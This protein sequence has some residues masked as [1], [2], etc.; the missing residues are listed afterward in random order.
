MLLLG[1]V[2]KNMYGTPLRVFITISNKII[3]FHYFKTASP[4]TLQNKIKT[5]DQRIS[6]PKNFFHLDKPTNALPP[7]DSIQYNQTYWASYTDIVKTKKLSQ[8]DYISP[9]LSG[10]ISYIRSS[11]STTINISQEELS[12]AISPHLASW[13]PFIQSLVQSST[14]TSPPK[15]HH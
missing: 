5:N 8:D 12:P 14:S 9:H 7:K 11:L 10:W 4:T 15:L 6:P 3:A 2:I 1:I 13:I